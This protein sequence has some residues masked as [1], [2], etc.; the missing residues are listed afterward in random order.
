MNVRTQGALCLDLPFSPLHNPCPSRQYSFPP[1]TYNAPLPR[2]R[3]PAA[4]PVYAL[5]E[6][7]WRLLKQWLLPLSRALCA[8]YLSQS[9]WLCLFSFY[10]CWFFYFLCISWTCSSMPSHL[11]AWIPSEPLA[12]CLKPAMNSGICFGFLFLTCYQHPT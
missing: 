5:T 9:T 2:P 10:C 3:S 8:V 7:M 12:Q 4:G 11:L 6:G 1:S